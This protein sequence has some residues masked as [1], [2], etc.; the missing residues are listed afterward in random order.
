MVKEILVTPQLDTQRFAVLNRQVKQLDRLLDNPFNGPQ[1]IGH[2]DALEQVGRL[3][4]EASGLTVDA[5]LAAIEQARDADSPIRLTVTDP[6][7]N[8]LPWELLYHQHPELG[9]LGCHPWCSIIR[10]LRGDGQKTPKALPLPFRLLLFIASPED[11]DPERSR[12]DFEREEELL[13]TALD[14]PLSKGEL[15][16]DV[17][18]DGCLRTLIDHLEQH[19]YHA[20][21][22]SMHGTE[23]PNGAGEKEG[24]LL[25][26]DEQSGRSAPITGRALA[27]RL[28]Q[29]PAGNRPGLV[30]LSACRSA[31][32]EDSADSIVSVARQLHERGFE[33][34]LGMRLSVLD[35]AAAAFSTELFRHLTRG[36]ETVGRAVTLARS[37]V[38]TGE[39]LSQNAPGGKGEAIGDIYAQWTL[40]VLLDRTADGPLVDRA[41]PFTASERLPLP[42]V[43][44]GDGTIQLPTRADFVGRR[45]FVRQHL[46]GFI[47]G[48]TRSLM[49]T[50]PGG[51]GKT[52]LA[53]LFA[54]RLQ[55]QLPGCRVL[56]FQAPFDLTLVFEALRRE[57]FD[58]NE[59][60]SLLTRLSAES[61]RRQQ[62]C[63]LLASLARRKPGCAFVLD[64]LESVQDLT[65]L[66]VAAEHADSRWFIK[67]VTALPA[68]TRLLFTNR[69]LF[70]E[71][72]KAVEESPVPDAPY[73]DV[74]R[75]MN[76][77]RWPPMLGLD[78]KREVY[79]VV[80]G[81]YRALEWTAQLL[82]DDPQ[83][84]AELLTALET[85][86]E[87]MR[88]NLLF[89]RLRAQLSAEQ[90]YLLRA[91]SLYRVP[92]TID[93]LYAVTRASAQLEVDRQRLAAY[94]LLEHA[95]EIGLDLNYV[96]VPPV[97]KMLLGDSSFAVT[98]LQTLHR[99]IGSYHRFQGQYVSQRWGDDIEAI[100][101]FRQAQEHIVADELAERVCRFYYGIG[102]FAVARTLTEEIVQREV[103][104][105]PCWAQSLRNEPTAA[106]HP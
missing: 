18:E 1:P 62:I 50:G 35:A 84:S 60:P 86:R 81:N 59:E 71:L 33:R 82:T 45:A 105:P 101:H 85:V 94:A 39:W 49:L 56:G 66:H 103:P 90:D 75:K 55:E 9:F 13:F 19:N 22:L 46:R 106:W 83:Q 74:L 27:V 15:T 6:S 52:T 14:G 5:L 21:I 4:W 98:E 67:E 87:A 23:I 16:I 54:R 76:R 91:V 92:V 34:V 79:R 65:S 80:G 51:V 41:A 57:A 104:P 48:K 2:T 69:Y 44:S 97:V 12:L 100:H 70:P 43:L 24:G 38:A 78:T 73:G 99:A 77:L 31:K 53:G 102:N 29:L 37:K 10:R 17:A 88:E 36:Q 7:F 42:S 25:L 63:L 95:H 40:P 26:E 61:D 8:H 72:A 58:G 30:I 64:N 20:V 47:T 93:G 11:L 32:A 89:D 3:L 68:P 28:E 96:V